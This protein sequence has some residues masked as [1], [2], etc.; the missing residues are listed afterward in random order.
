MPAFRVVFNQSLI[1]ERMPN[2]GYVESEYNSDGKRKVFNNCYFTIW[3]KHHYPTDVEL[4]GL[5]DKYGSTNF[6]E[7]PIPAEAIPDTMLAIE[8]RRRLHWD[9]VG[10][11]ILHNFDTAH[12]DSQE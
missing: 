3:K 1:Q 8:Q 7:Y 11:L 4:S 12:G 9:K 2:D 6:L 10:T 5:A